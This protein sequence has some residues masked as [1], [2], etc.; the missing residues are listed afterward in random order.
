MVYLNGSF[1]LF[2][3]ILF[4][5]FN[6]GIQNKIM[7][8]LGAALFPARSP[9]KERTNGICTCF[10]Y[11]GTSR[12]KLRPNRPP[13]RRQTTT[14][15]RRLL[16]RY[17]TNE[18]VRFPL[19][20]EAALGMDGRWISRWRICYGPAARHTAILDYLLSFHA[21]PG[22][23]YLTVHQFPAGSR[24]FLFSFFFWR[25]SSTRI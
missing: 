9:K 4:R 25:R 11:Q 21:P 14:V 23:P 5:Y 22:F 15:N 12:R 20:S 8:G 18:S 6:A 19:P 3:R 10:E 17:E 2:E 16:L 7:V 1:F 24:I 13:N